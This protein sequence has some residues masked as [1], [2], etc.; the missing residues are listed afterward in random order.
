MFFLI[1]TLLIATNLNYFFDNLCKAKYAIAKAN[2][3]E[4]KIRK[5]FFPP[6]KF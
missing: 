2:N 3:T 5:V 1:L 6:T 4:L